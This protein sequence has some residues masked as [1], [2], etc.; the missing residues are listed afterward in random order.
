MNQNE[1][2][3]VFGVFGAITSML[4][5]ISAPIYA[6]IYK[7]TVETDPGKVFYSLEGGL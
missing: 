3:T 6:F 5:M 4:P 1:F 7:H 2:G